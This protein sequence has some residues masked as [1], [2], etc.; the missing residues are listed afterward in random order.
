MYFGVPLHELGWL[1]LLILGGS[2]VTGLLAG[3]FGIGGGGIIVPILYEVFGVLG[4]PAD[5]RL[6]LCVGTSIL[7]IVPTNIRSFLAHRRRGAVLMDVVRVWAVPAVLG[8]AV[9]AIIAAFAPATVLKIAF[10]VIAGTISAKLLFGRDS[11]RLGAGLPGR[12]GMGIYGFIVGLA[13]SLMGISGGSLS[14]MIL[15]L[16]GTPIH[17]AVATSAG[18]GVPITIA[19]A[20][21]YMVAG[22]PHQAEMPPLSIGF[23]SFIGVAVMAPISSFIAPYGARLAH[24][25]PSRS[26]EIGFGIFLMLVSARFV[27]SMIWST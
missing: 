21:G 19:G 20:L 1:F 26:L 15:T 2:M 13:A 18:L 9:G 4:V 6:Q 5:V 7:I 11:W 12:I 22:L 25:L 23:V 17:R 10:I 8:V 16:Y 27:A 3:L 14:N 24:H